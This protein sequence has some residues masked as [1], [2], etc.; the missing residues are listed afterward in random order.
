[1]GHG[2]H[3]DPTRTKPDTVLARRDLRRFIQVFIGS[4]TPPSINLLI[5]EL[6]Y[7]IERELEE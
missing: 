3:S 4:R 5:N 6:F 1:M 2:Q 7:F